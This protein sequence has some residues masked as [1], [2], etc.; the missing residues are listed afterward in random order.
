[1]LLVKSLIQMYNLYID[2]FQQDKHMLSVL[3]RY[4]KEA[5]EKPLLKLIKK[6]D[7][8]S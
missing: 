8:F 4:H 1:M 5:V 3:D 6:E 7:L 2:T